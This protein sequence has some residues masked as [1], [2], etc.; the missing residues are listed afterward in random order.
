MWVEE[1]AKK[2][3]EIL[4]EPV[5]R[6]LIDVMQH[7]ILSHHGQPEFGAAR[8]PST[9]EAIAVHVIENLDAKLMMALRRRAAK[10]ERRRRK[11]NWTEYVKALGGRL[12]RPDVA[13][14]E[15]E[16]SQETPPHAPVSQSAPAGGK[17]VINNP[18]FETGSGNKR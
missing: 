12:Y 1:K 3:E 9:P 15:V 10:R 8:T 7:I 16:I 17:V 14:G 6:E 18:L 5:P 2:A 13:P 11:A 4:G